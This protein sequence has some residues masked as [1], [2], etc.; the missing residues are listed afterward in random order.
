[1]TP[2]RKNQTQVI[3]AVGAKPGAVSWS[4]SPA[5]I[6]LIL[7][8]TLTIKSLPPSLTARAVAAL[9]IVAKRSFL[10]GGQN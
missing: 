10:V 1:M 7:P 4:F 3:A 6:E 9:A 2:V 5:R 8:F